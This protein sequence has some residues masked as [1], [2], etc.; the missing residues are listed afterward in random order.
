[1]AAKQAGRKD[2]FIV[3]VDGA[4]EVVPFLKDPTS[5]IAATAAQDPCSMAEKAVTIGYDIINAKKPAEGVT[6]IPVQFITKNNVS[7]YKGG[8][9]SAA[10]EVHGI[11]KVFLEYRALKSTSRTPRF[12]RMI[13]RSS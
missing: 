1:L 6:L 12:S 5:L 2:F 9:N 7:S 11:S 10:L 13:V 3:S 4:P 8:L